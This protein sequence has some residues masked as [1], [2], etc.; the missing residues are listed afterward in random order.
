MPIATE[1][2]KLEELLVEQLR[3]D[4]YTYEEVCTMVM[5]PKDLVR[6]IYYNEN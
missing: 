3:A 4:G 1:T 6:E 5:L 2:D